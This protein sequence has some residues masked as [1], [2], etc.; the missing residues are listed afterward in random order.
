M[1]AARILYEGVPSGLPATFTC[2]TVAG[3]IQISLTLTLKSQYM[4]SPSKASCRRSQLLQ[5]CAASN[6]PLKWI[7]ALRVEPAATSPFVLPNTEV[8]LQVGD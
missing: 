3:E 6:T 1:C 8:E 5:S 7:G 2:G 4:G